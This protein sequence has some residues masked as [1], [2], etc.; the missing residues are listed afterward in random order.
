MNIVFPIYLAPLCGLILGAIFGSF[1]AAIVSRWPKEMS[2]MAG[3]SQCDACGKTLAARELVPIFSYMFQHGK[4]RSCGAVIDRDA[5]TIELLAAAI[6]GL[7]LLAAPDGHGVAGAVFGWLLLA[8]AWLDFRHF[9]L[10]DRLTVALALTG[11]TAA[12]LLHRADFAGHL[13]GGFAG[14]ALLWVI[15]CTYTKLRGREGLGGGD[16]KMLGGIGLW[17]GWAALPF[18][19]LG[20]STIGL[21][22][23]GVM[24]YRGRTIDA[25]TRLPLGS[26]MAVPA[27]IYWLSEAVLISAF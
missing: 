9:W 24:A 15:S 6:G 27:L 8:L 26:L 5:L 2:V 22:A 7:A 25:Q 10:P 17:L 13:I 23:I 20:A 14:F 12:Y 4:C 18:V 16:A 19:L 1:I 11:L 3:R 21:A